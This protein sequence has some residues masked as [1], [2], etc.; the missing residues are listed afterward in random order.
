MKQVFESIRKEGIIDLVPNRAGTFV[1]VTSKRL[2]RKFEILEEERL[3]ALIEEYN[4]HH[5]TQGVYL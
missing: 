3:K 2:R 1:E 4:K 5:S